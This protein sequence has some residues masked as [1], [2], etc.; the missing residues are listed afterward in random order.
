MDAAEMAL[1]A[2]PRLSKDAYNMEEG[3]VRVDRT[4]EQFPARPSRKSQLRVLIPSLIQP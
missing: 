3:I 4:T 1:S 2:Q